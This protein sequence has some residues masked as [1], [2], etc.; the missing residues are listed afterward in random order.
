MTVTPTVTPTPVYQ[1][2]LVVPNEYFTAGTPPGYA[3]TVNAVTAGYGVDIV[4]RCLNLLTYDIEPL[5]G[6]LALS[7]SAAPQQIQDLPAE[8]DMVNGEARVTPRFMDPGQTYTVSATDLSHAFVLSGSTRPIPCNPGSYSAYPFVVVEHASLAPA[9]AVQ[10]EQNLDM[11]I[12]RFSNPNS[13]NSAIY[14]LQGVTLTTQD[15]SGT[16]ILMDDILS[17]LD[18]I[19]EATGAVILSQDQFASTAAQYL[20]LTNGSLLIYPGQTL[21]LR[22]RVDLNLASRQ[23]NLRIG[24]ELGTQVNCIFL[25][26]TPMLA[27]SGFNDAFPMFSTD[28]VINIRDLEESYRNYPNPFAAGAQETNIEYFLE[29]NSTV[30]LRIYNVIGQLVRVIVDQE[31][32][33]GGTT[34]YRYQW[35]GRN[36]SGQ[37]VLNGIYFA[38]LTAKP[39]AGG[40][41]KRLIIKIAVIK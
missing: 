8:V 20:N 29:E 24:L 4:I 19:D 2:V 23:P 33:G 35:D 27:R 41:P 9:T 16:P 10:G 14:R 1:L 11:L 28:V 34:L 15:F 6:T 21:A 38:V 13:P 40:P 12:L 22:I 17:A 25:D 39:A 36:G 5:N 18:V 32:Q 7:T 37:V 26:G 31:A 3:G 30:S